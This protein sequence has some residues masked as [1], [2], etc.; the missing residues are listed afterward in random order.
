[1]SFPSRFLQKHNQQE[2]AILSVLVVVSLAL[3]ANKAAQI[4]DPLFIWQH[5]ARQPLDPFGFSVNWF[6]VEEPAIEVMKNP[7]LGPYFLSVIGTLFGWDVI[8]LHLAFILPALGFVFG[9]YRLGPRFGVPPLEATLLSFFS[10]AV[11][12]SSTT[13]MPDVMAAALWVW[14][15][16]AWM[17]GVDE[18]RWQFL[19]AGAAAATLAGLTKYVGLAVVLLM[20]VYLLATKRRLDRSLLYLLIPVCVMVGYNGVTEYLYGRSM[21][22]DAIAYARSGQGFP[23][24][25]PWKVPTTLAFI[26]GCA[27]V[28]LLFPLLLK[29]RRLLLGLFC[30]AVAMTAVPLCFSDLLLGDDPFWLETSLQFLLWCSV[31]G[32]VLLLPVI[33][34]VERWSRESLLLAVW[35]Y[36]VFVFA[37]FFNW[38]INAKTILLLVPPLVVLVLRQRERMESQQ[39]WSMKRVAPVVLTGLMGLAI[40]WGDVS[41]ANSARSAANEIHRIVQ[42]EERGKQ[43]WFQ[44]HWGFQYY[45]Q[46]AG[47]H[48]QT[49]GESGLEGADILVIPA[50]NTNLFGIER[51][52]V[53]SYKILTVPFQ[54][55][56]TTVDPW[57]KAGFYSDF[58]GFLPF[59]FGAV[60]DEKYY[61]FFLKRAGE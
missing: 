36:G 1:M 46:A 51:E 38:S 54:T 22:V 56:V 9:V 3:F 18:H 25:G 50:K 30:T 60:A 21:V 48:A 26:G 49:A 35:I 45:M 47:F 24:E 20:L 58:M 42:A 31:G 55:I 4:D 53:K 37:A 10:P 39:Q 14:A 41:F 34:L 17:R 28:A 59:A 6:G 57:R 16:V 11:L 61:I 7:P 19:L 27:G 33:E 2:S 32:F 15:L 13:L 43:V 44:G 40:A 52:K 8:T 12:V 29:R 23:R 5:L